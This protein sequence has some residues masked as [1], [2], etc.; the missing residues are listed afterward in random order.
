MI[1]FFENY[2]AATQDDLQKG[3]KFYNDCADELQLS[4]EERRKYD[5]TYEYFVDDPKVQVS[6]T[7]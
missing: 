4:L 5:M 1:L 6:S 7:I 2:Q 3:N